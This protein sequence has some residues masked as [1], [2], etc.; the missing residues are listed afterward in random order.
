MPGPAAVRL[1][2]GAAAR[3]HDDTMASI[4]SRLIR[5]D[6]SAQAAAAAGVATDAG[7]VH[8]ILRGM[9][10]ALTAGADAAARVDVLEDAK[11]TLFVALRP[12]CAS[13]AVAKALAL[14]AINICLA[15]G[16]YRARTTAVLAR[17]VG[18]IIDPANSC[19]LACPGCVHSQT[20]KARHVFD[21]GKG[22]LP[23]DR[24]ARYMATAGPYAIHA[25]FCNYGEPLVNPATPRFVRE[26]KRN[27]VLSMLS[28]NLSLPRLD[29]EAVVASGLDYMICSIDGA[30][31]P[32]YEKFRRKGRI[33]V[34]LRNIERLVKAKREQGKGT[35]MIVWRFLTFEHNVHEIPLAAQMARDLGV[36]QFLTETPFD[37]T[38]DAPDVRV[39][40]VPATDLLFNPQA[41]AA[42]YDNWNAHPDDVDA[43]A[44]EA[45]FDAPWA[46][47]ADPIF[48]SR[49]GD[50]SAPPPSCKWLYASM[51]MD[52]D[53][54]IMPCCG[55]PRPGIDLVFGQFEAQSAL[56]AFNSEKYRMSRL[57]LNDPAAH[58]RERESGRLARDTYCVGCTWP[59]EPNWSDDNVRQYF[60]AAGRG[61]FNRESV[62]L[63]TAW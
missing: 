39:A 50:G 14:K 63:M 19:N 16:E 38:W 55:S 3:R 35:P 41:T 23:A 31:Q 7:R 34:V 59:R 1:T 17:P 24:L 27:L 18:L 54:R 32:V 57:A 45:A 52:A 11:R 43:E 37:V 30:T 21:W 26:A 51:S 60:H 4:L 2:C 36:D 28:T 12:H 15:R 61:L 9:E 48:A 47:A 53:G 40:E 42:I 20:V 62:G 49:A 46:D 8:A 44:I 10:D 5:R 33:D 6:A 13:D 22:T 29:A 56:H 25:N 58:R